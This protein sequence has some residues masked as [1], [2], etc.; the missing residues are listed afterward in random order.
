MINRSMEFAMN[1]ERFRKVSRLHYRRHAAL[2]GN[3]SAHDIHDAL[4]YAF[5]CRIVRAR[6]NF[7]STNRDV[8]LVAQFAESREVHVEKRLLEPVVIQFF[9][10][11]THA[12][13]YLV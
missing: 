2:P 6:E 1:A 9:K 7:C 11:A 3:V 8:E 12:Q 5:R 10:F 13:S 4:R